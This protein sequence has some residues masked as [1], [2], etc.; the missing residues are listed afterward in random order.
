MQGAPNLPPNSTHLTQPLDVAFFRSMKRI[1]RKLLGEWKL[2]KYGRRCATLPKCLFPRLLKKLWDQL[3]I[4]AESNLINGFRKCSISP[5]DVQVLLDRLPKKNH[6]DLS[7]VGDSFT[8]FIE[9]RRQEIM[10]IEPA[11]KKKATNIVAG[12]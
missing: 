8:E 1:W 4:N 6:V 5:T 7:L 10:E 9:S 12:L 3:L 2:S 11:R